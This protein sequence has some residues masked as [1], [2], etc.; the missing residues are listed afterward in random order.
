[1]ATR[2][3]FARKTQGVNQQVIVAKA[4]NIT[5]DT[6]LADFIA[7]APLGEVGVYDGNGALHTD[8]I[9]ATEE[10]FFVIKTTEGIKRSNTYL[11]SETVARKKAYVAPVKQ[12]AAI[13]WTGSGGALNNATIAAGQIFSF[14]V[15]ETTEGYDPYPQWLYE[16]TA[17]STDATM[18]VIQ[19]L[20]KK[21]NDDN[22]IEHKLNRRLVNAIVKADATYG[23][24][25]M[26]GTTPTVTVTNGSTAVTLG[27]TT[28]TIDVAVGD[29][30][31]FDAAAAPTDSVGDIYKV[32]A[33][34]AGVG[35]TLNRPYQGVTQTFTEA[36]AEGTRVKKVTSIV[37]IGLRLTAIDTDT[38]FRLAV[39]EELI[40]ADIDN[41]VT[42]F[43]RGNGTYDQVAALEK[44]GNTFAGETT[45]NAAFKEKFGTQDLFAVDGETYDIITFQALSG[46]KGIAPEA[47]H[48]ERKQIT[49]AVAKSSGNVDST[50]DT[51]FGL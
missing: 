45:Q 51:L 11:K 1:M 9:G 30:I 48:Y 27:G 5:T 17:K 21:V 47:V 44:E 28:P 4:I 8:L 26:T 13:G 50:L 22:A 46:E 14:K 38:H 42:A 2:K 24:Y 49:V 39:Q 15:I 36:E 12:V 19:R 18:D 7:N 41:A 35:F 10:F 6:T 3:K 16:E 32:T 40:N 33:I 31:S 37:Q 29:Y 43:V 20:A 23:N 25:A 34:S